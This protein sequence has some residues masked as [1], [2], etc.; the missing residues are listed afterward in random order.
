MQ[1]LNPRISGL[2][3]IVFA[4]FLY[5]CVKPNP[6]VP[7][8]N[9][10]KAIRILAI[11]NSFSEDAI[12]SNLHELAEAAGQKVIIG[13][14]YIGGASLQLHL[15]N[16]L[17]DA[18]VYDYRK[19]D[20]TGVKTS[21]GNASISS[22]L[23]NENWD[24]ISFQQVSQNS[25]Q[26]ETIEAS[27]PGLYN[28]VKQRATNPN[29]RYILH[30]TWAYQQNSSHFGFINYN[31]DQMT[32]YNSIVN[33]YIKAKSLITTPLLIPSGTAIQNIRSSSIG[34]NLTR[35][36]YHLSIPLGRYTAACTW[37]ESIFGKSVVGNSFAPAELSAF[38]K[39]AAQNAAHYA[40]QQPNAVTSMANFQ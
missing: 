31:N 21:A 4:F 7:D 28:Y 37:Y 12:E 1:H 36:G 15:Q 29:V 17:N 22:V 38:E 33:A 23:N 10:Q 19:I 6:H 8:P 34:D 35:D 3:L 2:S 25:G 40:V 5:S 39:S 26:Y 20:S 27:L 30:Q 18:P 16:A 24:Y 32:M 13:N 11:G 9:P 14:M